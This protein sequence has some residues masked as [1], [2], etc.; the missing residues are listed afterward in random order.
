MVTDGVFTLYHCIIND[1]PVHLSVP[2]KGTL[3]RSV[4][5]NVN[6]WPVVGYCEYLAWPCFANKPNAAAEYGMNFIRAGLKLSSP[7]SCIWKHSSKD[8]CGVKGM[9][10]I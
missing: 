2:H 3:T 4:Y 8:K 9:C 7:G 10:Y 6:R 5:Y 1:R